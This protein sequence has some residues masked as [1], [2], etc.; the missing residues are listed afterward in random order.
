MLKN[1]KILRDE[2]GV[3]QQKLADEIG[4]SQQ[5][6]NAYENS[7]VEPDIRTLVKIAVFFE[8]SVDFVVG[9]TSIRRKIEIVNE[10]D[11]NKQET[12]HIVHYRRLSTATRKIIDDLISDKLNN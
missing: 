6:V 7:S 12:E 1:I 8:T 5:S 4:M 9:N 2:Y 3:S 10:F 11:L